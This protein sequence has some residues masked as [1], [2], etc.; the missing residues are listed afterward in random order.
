MEISRTIQQGSVPTAGNKYTIPYTEIIAWKQPHWKHDVK[1]FPKL[2]QDTL[3]E[4]QCIY[5]YLYVQT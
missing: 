2:L 4:F 3:Y 1:A 5:T